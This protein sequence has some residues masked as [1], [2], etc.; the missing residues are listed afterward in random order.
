MLASLRTLSR[1][2]IK[3]LGPEKLLKGQ[4]DLDEL[5]VPAWR[6]WG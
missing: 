2:K 4:E 3:V 1:M 6:S 5:F